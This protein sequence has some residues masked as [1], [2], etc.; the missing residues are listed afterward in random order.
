VPFRGSQGS[1]LELVNGY[2]CRNCA[3]A[4]LAKKGVDPAHPKSSNRG[5]SGSEAYVPPQK[6]DPL[7]PELGVNRASGVAG[8]GS[9][10]VGRYLDLRA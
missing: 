2:Y 7:H 5:M 1:P 3:D 8:T 10:A 9:D 6:D 4:E